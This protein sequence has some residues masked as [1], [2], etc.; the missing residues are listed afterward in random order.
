MMKGI[1]IGTILVLIISVIN[2]LVIG[3]KSDNVE[4][5]T[6]DRIED[7]YGLKYD[8]RG[9]IINNL[10]D[11]E[12]VSLVNTY[13]N[14]P[15]EIDPIWLT[16]EDIVS[17]YSMK[18]YEDYIY[19]SGAKY[20]SEEKPCVG[21]L[22]K[23]NI[24]DGELIW[25]RTWEGPF[26]YT[27]AYGVDIYN[28][29]IYVAGL[30]IPWGIPRADSFILKYDF[31]GN[32]LWN[33][34]INETKYDLI[35]GV[36]AYDNYLYL[37]GYRNNGYEGSKSWILK[38]DTDSNKIWSKYYEIQG[39]I[40]NQIYD[41]DIY[42]GYIFAEGQTDTYDE[43]AQDLLVVKISLD[44]EL[45]WYREWG[46]KGNQ[47]GSGIDVEDGYI[48]V[49]S[50]HNLL[51]YDTEGNLQWD[52]ESGTQSTILDIKVFNGSIYT[53]GE[54]WGLYPYDRLWDAV[55]QKHDTNGKLIWYLTYGEKYNND[56]GKCIET[57]ND[58]FYLCGTGPNK[59]FIFNYDVDLFSDNNKPDIPSKPSGQTSGK[60]GV[61]Y[62][63]STNTTD[64]DGDLISYDFSWGEEN[65]TMT[66]WMNSGETVSA[67]HSWSE[68]G[69]YNV[70]VRARDE[71][72]FVSDWSEPLEITMPRNKNAWFQGWLERFSLLQKI[73]DLLILNIR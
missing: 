15:G 25:M 42:N 58:S 13:N 27:R 33:K 20:I 11:R 35:S 10:L 2:P 7:K 24:T 17:F 57:Y 29:S 67:S 63:Y 32:L 64:P 21:L 71:C 48:Y 12:G 50:Y 59:A 68:R 69:K 28:G 14:E 41:F 4:Y 40:I 30:S 49:C 19:V 5:V 1:S 70:R 72:G 9:Y 60:P 31:N 61:E 65:I 47:L 56:K 3:Y 55:L 44:G 18:A 73:L 43:N 8:D 54:I 16:V 36:K 46:G 51:K 23:F 39:A 45:I 34:L 62:T 26:V 38:Y 66:E 53:T 37:C 22:A 6:N 52:A